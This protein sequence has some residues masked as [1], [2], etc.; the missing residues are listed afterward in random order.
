MI[1]VNMHEAKTRL[2][3]LLAAAEQGELVL[4]CRNGRP[5]AE[6][7]PLP[8]PIDPLRVDPELSKVEFLDDPMAPLA[9]EDWPE[10]E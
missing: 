8:A 4:L 5:V 10:P 2:S 6:L 7:R 1:K 9:P 3:A